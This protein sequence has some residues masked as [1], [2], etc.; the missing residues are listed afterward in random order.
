L[1]ATFAELKFI[2]AEAAFETAKPRSY[3]AYLAGIIA[4]M[5]MLG[6]SEAEKS[7]YLSSPVVS[8]GAAALTLN[9]I[10]KEKWIALFLHPETWNDARRFDYAYKDMTLPENLNPSLNGEYI[11]RLAYPDSEI[12]RNGENVPSTTLLDRIWWDQ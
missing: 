12:S 4:H 1:I 11:R 5:N 3:A 7:A 8:M 10:M 6:V 2:E 9:D